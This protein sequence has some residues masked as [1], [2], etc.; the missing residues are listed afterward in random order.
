MAV[1][2]MESNLKKIQEEKTY[3]EKLKAAAATTFVVMAEKGQVDDAT[4]AEQGELFGEWAPGVSYAAGALRRWQGVLYRCI[5][6]H[7]SQE[8]WEPP[9]SASLWAVTGDPGEEWPQWRQPMGAHDTYNAGD[10]AA[11]K[12]QHWISTVNGNVWEPGVYGWE[13]KGTE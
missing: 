10:K 13:T 5:H 1:K 4:A 9:A 6:E 7:T 12:G 2:Y 8:G 3:R 11:H